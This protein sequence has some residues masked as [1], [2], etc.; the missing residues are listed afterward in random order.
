MS[1]VNEADER[2]LTEIIR[3]A[4]SLFKRGVLVSQ[5]GLNFKDRAQELEKINAEWE[6][7][8]REVDDFSATLNT[9]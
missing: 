4:Q 3:D 2:R 9:G 1:E 8:G 6:K 7:L 5:I